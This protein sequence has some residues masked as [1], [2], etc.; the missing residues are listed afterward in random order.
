[1]KS[2]FGSERKQK[3]KKNN[4]KAYFFVSQKEILVREQK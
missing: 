3:E 1:L 4:G 2:G